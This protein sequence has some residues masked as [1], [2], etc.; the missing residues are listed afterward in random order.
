MLHEL[1]EV[2]PEAAFLDG[3][4]VRHGLLREKQRTSLKNYP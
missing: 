2:R 3:P 4:S 1:I